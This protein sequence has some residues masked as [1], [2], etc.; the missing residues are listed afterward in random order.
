LFTAAS[1]KARAVHHIHL[2][3]VE[4]HEPTAFFDGNF[5]TASNRASFLVKLAESP[6]A[7][8]NAAMRWP[9]RNQILLPFLLIQVIALTTIAGLSAW[10]A[11][12][13]VELSLQSRLT[14]VIE[15]L[16]N[17]SFPLTPAILQQLKLLS[18]ADFVV[19]ASDGTLVD[20]TLQNST[21]DTSALLTAERTTQPGG[22][23]DHRAD[24]ELNNVRYFAQQFLWQG[25][26]EP[27]QVFVLYPEETYRIAR[28]QAMWPPLIVGGGLLLVT[29]TVSVLLSRRFNRRLLGL[30]TQVQTIAAGS[31]TPHPL[32]AVDDEL[33]DVAVAVN[34]MA[35]LLEQSL[36]N[37]RQTERSRLLTQLVG[38][39]AHQ[40]RNAITGGRLSVQLHKRRCPQGDD[41]SLRV[42]LQQLER[43]EEQIKGLLRIARG[44]ERTRVSASLTDVMQA[45]VELI[46][47]VCEHQKISFTKAVD[48][49]D[50]MLADGDGMR[51]ALLNLLMNAIEAAGP[52]GR[53]RMSARANPEAVVI[54]ISDNGPGFEDVE[55]AMRPFFSTK[56]EGIGLGL[57]LAVQGVEDCGGTLVTERIDDETCF[58]LTLPAA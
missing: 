22:L 1:C 48:S 43:I 57:A 46:E 21:S 52:G 39:L 47:P 38:G 44:E 50:L 34:Q 41:E 6:A 54:E 58:R 35:R 37:A 31:F 10:V 24:V 30:R 23:L 14:N 3:P 11:V 4:T 16:Q 42:A 56:Q 25:A 2:F 36:E 17:A 28:Q 9:L 51:A 19:L 55:S 29:I 20:A 49:P 13:R 40:L 8:H 53:V 27:R 33:R 15:T 5:A 45:T 7:F 32:P 18:G 12:H 26:V